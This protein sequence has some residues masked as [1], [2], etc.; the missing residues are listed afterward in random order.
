MKKTRKNK[1]F[2]PQAL[3]PESVLITS[4][5]EEAL[6]GIDILV[7]GI[8][9]QF[10]RSALQEHIQGKLSS[11]IPIVSLSKGIEN[12]TMLRGSQIFREVLGTE[13]LGVLS[14]PSHAEE[15][16]QGMPTSI[17]MASRNL[18]FAQKISRGVD[19][20]AFPNLYEP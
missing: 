19:A 18:D 14:G 16:V 6:D 7:N 10:I 3:I 12:D 2:L 1:T 20:K 8:P 9:T 4:T 5:I 15:V 17:V 11:S 13:T